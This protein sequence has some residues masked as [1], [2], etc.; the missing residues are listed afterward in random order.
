MIRENVHMRLP[1][2]HF[3][4]FSL[5]LILCPYNSSTLFLSDKSGISKQQDKHGEHSRL[6]HGSGIQKSL[7]RPA[8]IAAFPRSSHLTN[9]LLCTSVAEHTAH[10]I[11][12]PRKTHRTRALFPL[13]T[14]NLSRIDTPEPQTYPEAP[15]TSPRNTDRTSA[16]PLRNKHLTL[17][18]INLT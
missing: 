7:G 6:R 1:T 8:H 16:F 15:F 18:P 2:S 13:S 4:K 17:Y 11:S 5:T 10:P 3:F 12:S 14:A 9:T